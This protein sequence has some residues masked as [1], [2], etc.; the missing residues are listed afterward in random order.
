[1]DQLEFLKLIVRLIE[2]ANLEY[3]I[4]GSYASGYWGEPRSTYD[5][6]IVVA[7]KA[8][9]LPALEKLFPIDQFYMSPQA[10]LDAIAAAGQFNV[11]HP[12]SGNKV[13]FMMQSN[14]SWG[15]QQL[16]HRK[17][18]VFAPQ[19]EAWIGAP[20]DVIISKMRYYREGGSDK[21]LRDIAGMMKVSS[22][23]IDRGYIAKWAQDLDLMDIWQA[24]LSRIGAAGK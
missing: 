10:A 13:D 24:I 19:F 15:Q 6:D 7:F 8:S 23:L 1:M 4:V 17:R 5:V 11:I 14:D 12:E 3:M 2:Q 9:D 21:H 18:V 16:R 22:D 20:E